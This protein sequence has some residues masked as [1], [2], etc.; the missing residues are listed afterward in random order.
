MFIG[1]IC[2][3]KI[4]HTQP[5]VTDSGLPLP[6][7]AKVTGSGNPL[8]NVFYLLSI[9]GWLPKFLVNSMIFAFA[10]AFA[11]ISPL[12][13]VVFTFRSMEAPELPCGNTDRWKH[14]MLF[15][16]LLYL[17]APYPVCGSLALL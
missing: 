10:F 14:H 11:L 12:V 17:H 4:S 7:T 8:G 9:C 13:T 15:Q 6:V 5:A 1:E 3:A 2:Q 16:L